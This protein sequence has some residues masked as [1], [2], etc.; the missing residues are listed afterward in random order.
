MPIIYWQC[1]LLLCVLQQTFTDLSINILRI[2]L[3]VLKNG[4]RNREH[5]NR[6]KGKKVFDVDI[7][8]VKTTLDESSDPS[9]ESDPMEEEKEKERECRRSE[10]EN[11]DD[12][13]V[14]PAQPSIH[15]KDIDTETARREKSKGKEKK[16]SQEAQNRMEKMFKPLSSTSAKIVNESVEKGSKPS[17]TNGHSSGLAKTPSL[18]FSSSHAL[19]EKAKESRKE[20]SQDGQTPE[21]VFNESCEGSKPS[22][23]DGH[24]NGLAKASPLSS[25]PPSPFSAAPAASPSS[26]ATAA[27]ATSHAALIGYSN[28]FS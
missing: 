20:K 18:S 10:E 21:N 8:H 13:T 16:K 9:S 27:P 26:V 5:S 17:T 11:A 12:A 28:T 19:K 15:S 25:S 4:G 23:I 1:L 3:Q 24:L 14:K 7:T 22:T 6:I 2:C